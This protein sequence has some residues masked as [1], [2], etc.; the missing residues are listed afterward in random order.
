MNP[1]DVETIDPV[2]VGPGCVRRDVSVEGPVR[3][4][5][6]D[7]APG[8]EWPFTDQHDEMG[9]LVYVVSG[10]LIEGETRYKAGTVV[11]YGPHSSH[12]PRT[13]TGV[14]LFGYNPRPL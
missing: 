13:Q 9:E 11:R 4:W 6:I 7:M 2:F 14:R 1:V 8:S 5:V 3:A 12:R 10:E